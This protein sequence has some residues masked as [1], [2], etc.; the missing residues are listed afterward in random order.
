MIDLRYRA[1]DLKRFLKKAKIGTIAELQHAL[2]GSVRMTVFRKLAELGYQTSYSHNGRFY[3]LKELCEFGSDGLWSH[4][5]VWFSV[6]GTLLETGR[7]FIGQS[8]AGYSVH[9][10]DEA[11]HVSTKQS[12]LHLSNNNKIAREKVGGVYVYFSA[13]EGQRRR[14]IHARG[15][16]VAAH[17]PSVEEDVLAHELKAAIILFYSVLDERQRRFFAGLESIQMGRGGDAK[18]ARLLGIDPHTVAKG[19]SELLERDLGGGTVRKRGSGRKR[20]EKKLPK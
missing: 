2:G 14:Q 9:E 18:V 20:L 3:S 13:D 6:Y 4:Q 15:G 7:N 1:A 5:D 10:L 12:L 8:P 16:L 19:R 17:S 11:L